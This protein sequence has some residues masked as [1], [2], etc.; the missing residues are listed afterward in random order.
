ME[1]TRT[2]VNRRFHLIQ[3]CSSWREQ[4]L[5]EISF[6]LDRLDRSSDNIRIP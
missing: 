5:V 1:L 3:L 2:L 4:A 6:T